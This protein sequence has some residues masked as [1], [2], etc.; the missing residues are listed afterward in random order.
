MQSFREDCCPTQN[1]RKKNIAAIP[2]RYR[3]NVHPGPRFR[4]VRA[5]S[6][7]TLRTLSCYR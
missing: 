4:T 3:W 2:R 6:S 5:E 1:L 7:K